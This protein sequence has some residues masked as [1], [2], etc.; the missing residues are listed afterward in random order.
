MRRAPHSERAGQSSMPTIETDAP[1]VLRRMD[2][3]FDSTA[4][5]KQIKITPVVDEHR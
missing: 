2:F 3:Q 5:G 1:K 4:H